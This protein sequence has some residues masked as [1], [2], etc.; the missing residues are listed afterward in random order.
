MLDLVSIIGLVGWFVQLVG[1]SSKTVSKGRG[2]SQRVDGALAENRR[3]KTATMVLQE[4]DS[5][6]LS[7][8]NQSPQK[9]TPD[10]DDQELKM[11]MSEVQ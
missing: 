8:L 11:P 10:L 4:L 7:A 5:I 6:L 2:L 9:G 1:S 3:I